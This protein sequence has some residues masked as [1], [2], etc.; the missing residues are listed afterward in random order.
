MTPRK[1]RPSGAKHKIA[2]PAVKLGGKPPSNEFTPKR[3]WA[4]WRMAFIKSAHAKQG[5]GCV[6]CSLPK[7]PAGGKTLVLHK[8][9]KVFVLLNRYP[10]S[11]GHLMVIPYRHIARLSDLT[12]DEQLEMGGLLAKSVSILEKEMKAQG[13][14]IGLNLGRAAG[15]GIEGHLH[16]HVVP[17]W[18]GDSNFMPVIGEVRVMPEHLEATYKSLKGHFA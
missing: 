14:N 4:P 16:Y 1:A 6:F 11:N 12:A 10:Y 8:G 13:F 9:R 18:V 2:F 17:R 15:A 5:G 7:K 3:L